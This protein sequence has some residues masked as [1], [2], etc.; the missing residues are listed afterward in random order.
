M[1]DW[2]N[3]ADKISKYFTVR[4]CLYLPRWNR[5]ATIEDGLDDEIKANLVLLC[6]RDDK[7]RDF[8]KSGIVTHCCYRPPVYNEE[9]GGAPNSYHTKGFARDWHIAGLGTSAGCDNARLKLIP[10][11]EEFQ[12]RMEDGTGMNWV[13]TDYGAVVHQRFFKP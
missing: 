6:N 7:M 13:H 2:T 11:L 5:L 1:I 9:V 12:M 10:K 8:L 4:D 3:G